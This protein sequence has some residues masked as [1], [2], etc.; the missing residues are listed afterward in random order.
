MAYL[1]KFRKC[2]FILTTNKSIHNQLRTVTVP[3]KQRYHGDR[4]TPIAK[5]LDLKNVL[6]GVL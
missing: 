2:V 4:R 1:Y 6:W 5:G 3:L